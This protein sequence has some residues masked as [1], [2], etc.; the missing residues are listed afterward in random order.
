MKRYQSEDLLRMMQEA[1]QRW[2]ALH[3]A[4]QPF[5]FVPPID[6]DRT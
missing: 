1:R 6:D 4:V 3:T 5:I 2:N